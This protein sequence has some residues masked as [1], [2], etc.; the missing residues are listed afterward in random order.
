MFSPRKQQEKRFF[1]LGCVPN[2]LALCSDAG[3]LD[4]IVPQNYGYMILDANQP[5]DWAL[6]AAA[7]SDCSV[8]PMLQARAASFPDFFTSLREHGSAGVHGERAD[9][10]RG[11]AL[12][13]RGAG[14]G[15]SEQ[16]PPP[17]RGRRLF[18]VR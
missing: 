15:R 1:L 18:L 5:L 3:L 9:G 13:E 10:R 8:Y 17:R 14:A 2:T 4:Y 16:C 7:G 6:D 11:A 12:R